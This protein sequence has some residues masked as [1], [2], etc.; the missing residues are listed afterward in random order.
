MPPKKVIKEILICRREFFKQDI[1]F[2]FINL[3]Y[4]YITNLTYKIKSDV[5]STKMRSTMIMC[6]NNV[7]E[8]ISEI[9]IKR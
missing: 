9:V 1:V 4:L 8:N 2:T 5:K 3:F 7:S 6:N